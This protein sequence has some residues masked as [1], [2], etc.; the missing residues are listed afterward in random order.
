M[1]GR[2]SSPTRTLSVAVAPGVTLSVEEA[3][4]LARCAASFRYF[5]PY[6]RFV[7]RETG[8]IETLADLWPGQE[9][10]ADLMKREPWL[11]ALKA[12]K[13]GFTELECAYDAWVA[14]FRQANARVH[15]FSRSLEAA[16]DLKRYVAFG[17]YHL[18]EWMRLPTTEG[19]GSDTMTSI[20]LSAGLDDERTI[21]CY[22]AGANTSIDQTA[23]HTH[24]DEFAR[25][26]FPESTWTTVETTVAPERGTCHIVTR[27][28]GAA[29][30]AATLW[31]RAMAGQSRLYPFFTDWRQR[32]GRDGAW[33]E[34]E[35]G[36]HTELGIKQYAPETWE[37]AISG[38]GVDAVIPLGWITEAIGRQP[39]S[40]GTV[41]AGLDVARYGSDR[42]ALVVV[43]DTQLVGME[44]WSGASVMESAARAL[45][46]VE[47]FGIQCLAVDD[48]GVGGGLTDA[49][50]DYL[51]SPERTVDFVLVPIEFQQRAS[52]PVRFHNKA[53][54]MW[55][56]A[57][58]TFSDEAPEQ[59]ILPQHHPALNRLVMQ[60]AGATYR[61][62][63]VGQGR[64]WVDKHGA[65]GQSRKPGEPQPESPDLA[66]AFILAL[67]AWAVYYTDVAAPEESG[68]VVHWDSW[69]AAGR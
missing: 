10:F 26:P 23:T 38:A 11:F 49:L 63:L 34:R 54:E 27:G 5:L 57:R 22:A 59:V 37:D 41:C 15:L 39:K 53:S 31:Q 18:P 24:L 61:Y 42:T 40:G 55:W 28:A 43:S 13:L 12:G 1:T 21:F 2:S 29:N 66:D 35:R 4:E 3:G 9:E 48:G 33:Y 69:I 62:D 52:D 17:L 50:A 7:N 30:F 65:Q 56:R 46:F 25:M 14:R 19:P 32:P 47:A 64:I 16:K 6:W 51:Q 60:L 36:E 67:E 44:E 20:R 68:T 58:E 8:R 45:R